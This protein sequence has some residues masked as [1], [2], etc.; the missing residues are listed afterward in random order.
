MNT[1]QFAVCLIVCALAGTVIGMALSSPNLGFVIGLATGAAIAGVLIA[2]GGDLGT[3]ID[4]SQPPD[5]ML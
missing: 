5:S 4:G 3:D 2:L 1:L